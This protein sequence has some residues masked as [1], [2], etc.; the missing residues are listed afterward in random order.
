[1]P[2]GSSLGLTLPSVG[3]TAGPD[4]AELLNEIAQALIDAVEDGVSSAIGLTITGDVAMAGFALSNVDHVAWEN[5]AASFATASAL[6]QRSNNLWYNDGSGN[7]IQLT[8]GG[9]LNAASLGGIVG[10]YGGANPAKVTYGDAAAAY[11]FTQDPNVPAK[12]DAGDLLLREAGATGPNAI[13]V[14]SPAAL[15]TAYSLTLPATLPVGPVQVVTMSS[16]GAL[17]TT[18]SPSVTNLTA[19]GDISATGTVTGVGVA[20]TE[21]DIRHGS[22]TVPLTSSAFRGHNG[23]WGDENP[24]GGSA[25]L[26]P[27]A[28]GGGANASYNIPIAVGDTLTEVRVYVRGNATDGVALRLYEVD[29][30]TGATTQRGTTQTAALSATDQTLTITGLSLVPTATTAYL[31]SVLANHSDHRIYGGHFKVSRS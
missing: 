22:R 20:T 16:S 24:S 6:Y 5:K 29:L 13:T 27:T 18:A 21:A 14:K 4:W 19:S 25:Y 15:A 3:V 23:D 10:D 30:T 2:I 26:S 9:A 8:V 12:I 11:V 7:Q 28:S 1:M 31:I 17:A